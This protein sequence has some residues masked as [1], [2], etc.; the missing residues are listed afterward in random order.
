MV[1]HISKDE[2]VEAAEPT[3]GRTF[4]WSE[5]NGEIPGGEGE[6]PAVIVEEYREEQRRGGII[7]AR[8]DRQ[9]QIFHPQAGFLLT[10]CTIPPANAAFVASIPT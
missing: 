10:S 4:M 5:E 6:T 7:R 1:C 9:V 3:I 8:N 2:D